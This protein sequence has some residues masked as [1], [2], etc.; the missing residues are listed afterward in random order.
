MVATGAKALVPMG[1]PGVKDLTTIYTAHDF[2]RGKFTVPSGRVCI[3]GGGEVACET[4]ET[5][6]VNSR[7]DLHF[8]GV[9]NS[10][11]DIDI[12]IIEMLP[13]VLTGV[14][15][16]NRAPSMRTLREN[17]VHINVNTKVLEVHDHSVKVQRLET[18]K[19]E[20][21]EGFD[22]VIFGMGARAYDPLSEQLKEFVPEVFV[23]GDA[24]KPGQSSEAMHQGFKVAYDL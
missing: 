20:V 4:A 16:P 13:K 17:D 19:E 8:G 3:L 23:I 14:C 5:I 6:L 7:P 15:V 10:I 18:G 12:T 21:L 24:V 22:Y 9:K 2:L 1:I 11:G